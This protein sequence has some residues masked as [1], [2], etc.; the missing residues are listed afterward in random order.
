MSYKFRIVDIAGYRF[1]IYISDGKCSGLMKTCVCHKRH[2]YAR[3]KAPKCPC[4]ELRRDNPYVAKYVRMLLQC[5]GSKKCQHAAVVGHSLCECCSDQKFN[6]FE[7]FPN[8]NKKHKNRR[9]L[10]VK[11]VRIQSALA[12]FTW[13]LPED[14]MDIVSSYF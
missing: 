14:L 5:K 1:A 3:G 11:Y 4:K 10:L 13:L 6:R 7:K 12:T 8:Y 2:E 9:E